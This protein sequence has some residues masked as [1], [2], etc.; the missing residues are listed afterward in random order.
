MGPN[1]FNNNLGDPTVNLHKDAYDE[2]IAAVEYVPSFNLGINVYETSKIAAVV[3]EFD[4]IRNIIWFN[5]PTVDEI[6][7]R[8]PK[9]INGFLVFRNR[10]LRELKTLGETL[11]PHTMTQIA[12]RVW[13]ATNDVNKAVFLTLANEVMDSI[14]SEGSGMD[15]A[16]TDAT[17]TCY[18]FRCQ[19]CNGRNIVR[20]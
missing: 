12:A 2:L 8:K 15:V 10:L 9:K 17:T 19:H 1:D 14:R 7:R 6:K 16:G 3:Y 20:R 4:G 11:M 18:E 5:L 13:R